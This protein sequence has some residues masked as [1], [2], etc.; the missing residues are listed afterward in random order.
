MKHVPQFSLTSSFTIPSDWGKVECLDA[1]E[2][3]YIVLED[4]EDQQKEHLQ[5]FGR[6]DLAIEVVAIAVR[7]RLAAVK[8]A[9]WTR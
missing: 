2:G 5:K 8:T 6:E 1:I 9:F 4:L 3:L 7:R